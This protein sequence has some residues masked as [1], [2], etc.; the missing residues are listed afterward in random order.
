M[1]SQ[2]H[3]SVEIEEKHEETQGQA[4]HESREASASRGI[5]LWGGEKCNQLWWFTKNSIKLC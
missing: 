3:D 5:I 2:A 1:Q 4:N